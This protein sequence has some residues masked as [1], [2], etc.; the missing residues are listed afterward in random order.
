LA[1]RLR[2]T[3]ALA[4]ALAALPMSVS[5]QGTGDYSSGQGIWQS[6]DGDRSVGWEIVGNEETGDAD[7]EFD[8]RS[9]DGSF[10]FHADVICI[11]VEDNEAFLELDTN[12]DG[13]AEY[14]VYAVDNGGTQSGDTFGL[15]EEDDFFLT[16]ED[17]EEDRDNDEDS[18]RGNIFNIDGS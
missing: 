17:C 8:V 14:E 10:D 9:R 11:R 13:D 18:I 3:I 15:K 12:A 6:E 5:A 16:D 2:F 1:V 7:G 4:L